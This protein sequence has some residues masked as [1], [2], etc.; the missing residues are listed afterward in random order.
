MAAIIAAKNSFRSRSFSTPTP[1]CADRPVAAGEQ[2]TVPVAGPNPTTESGFFTTSKQRLL[3]LITDR[4]VRQRMPLAPQRQIARWMHLPHED[5]DHLL[6]RV[7]R[8]RGVVEAAPA[9]RSF[10]A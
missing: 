1:H 4:L 2:G 8:E 9:K 10:R 5:H 6:F 7:D 3:H